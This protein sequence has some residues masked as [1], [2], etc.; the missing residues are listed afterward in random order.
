MNTLGIIVLVIII[1]VLVYACT[2]KSDKNCVDCTDVLPAKK[3]PVVSATPSAAVVPVKKVVAPQA[4]VKAK[5][6]AKKKVAKK[7]TKKSK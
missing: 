5:A 2:R 4:P 6:P 7:V 3:L 1:A